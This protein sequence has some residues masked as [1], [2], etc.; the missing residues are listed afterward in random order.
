MGIVTNTQCWVNV[1]VVPLRGLFFLLTRD[2]QQGQEGQMTSER[3][4]DLL[5]LPAIKQMVPKRH[6]AAAW[7]LTAAHGY[8]LHVALTCQTHREDTHIQ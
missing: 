8:I 5:S 1:R 6:T 2:V 4:C 3:Q 7:I